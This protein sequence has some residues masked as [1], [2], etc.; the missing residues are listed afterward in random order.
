MPPQVKNTKKKQKPKN[1]KPVS[2]S[3]PK[4]KP[5][6][7]AKKALLSKHV[8][9][10]CSILDPFCIHARAARRP[11]GMSFNTIPYQVRGT[12]Y[13]NTDANGNAMVSIIP[14]YGRYYGAASAYTPPW[15]IPAAWVAT[16]GATFIA[17][18]A[19]EVRLV[20]FGANF[21]NI[22]SMTN[23]SGLLHTFVTTSI[24]TAGTIPVLSSINAEDMTSPMTSGLRVAMVGKPLGSKAHSFNA[25][26][27]ITTTMSDFDW[28]ILNFEIAGGAVNTPV[29]VIEYVYNIEIQLSS[30]GVGTTGLGPAVVGTKPAN[31]VALNVQSSVH[32]SV[33][34]IVKGGIESLGSKIETAAANAISN[35]FDGAADF[36]LSFLGL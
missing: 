24:A 18:N 10:A 3:L 34:S 16:S 27:N 35:L 33:P 36:G 22:A 31:P 8:R 15:T 14:A 17:N 4:Q 32:S 5:K 6:Q 23:C 9:D 26:A 13:V 12:L 25:L 7:T 28:T 29:G 20:S 21:T 11:D 1:K 2:R 19:A 30:G